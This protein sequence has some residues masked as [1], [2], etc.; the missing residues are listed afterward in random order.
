MFFLLKRHLQFLEAKALNISSQ[1]HF[2]PKTF[3][4][5]VDE[6]HGRYSTNK[7]PTR[8]IPNKSTPKTFNF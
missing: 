8:K 1:N 5:Y 7:H 6:S 4:R 3:K 2:A